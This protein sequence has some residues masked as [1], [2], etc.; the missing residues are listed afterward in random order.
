[1]AP[2]I[3]IATSF[4]TDVSCYGDTSGAIAITVSGGTL[5]YTFN[6]TG[7]GIFNSS[8]E[9]ISNLSAGDYNLILTDGNGCIVTHG[10]VTITQPGPIDIS[11]EY[12]PKICTGTNNGFIKIDVSGGM[13]P[14]QYTWSNGS[15]NQDL[16]N[17]SAGTY[18]VTVTDWNDCQVTDS[19][20]IVNFSSP[21][22]PQICLVTVNR[23]NSIV[24]VWEKTYNQR[25]AR[26]NIYREQTKN[27][28]QKIGTVLFDSL[29]IFVDH[30]SIPDEISH[31]YKISVTDSCGNESAMSPYHKSIHL[32]TSMGLS[33]EINLFWDEYEGFDYYEYVIYRGSSLDGLYNIRNITSSAKSWT[34]K[35]P[36]KGQVYYLVEV[37]RPSPCFPTKFKADDY[38]STFSNYDEE[39]IVGIDELN[40]HDLMIC[41]NPFSEQTTILFPNSSSHPYRLVL[42]DLSGRV[43]KILGNITTN[44][45]VLSRD[46]LPAGIYLLKLEGTEIYRGKIVIE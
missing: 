21:Q 3:N 32:Q 8:D 11:R 28:Y 26:Y 40:S 12:S 44:E 31:F 37:V 16:T 13:A 29:S 9:D 14:Y 41:P 18:I 15:Y 35:S 30:S 46:S 17:L 7:P 39:T 36:P 2:A 45:I 20:Q 5:P 43:I 19:T 24:V 33:T 38:G 25:I 4:V 6:W 42:T 1:M 10:P 27:N 23:E 22:T 34:D